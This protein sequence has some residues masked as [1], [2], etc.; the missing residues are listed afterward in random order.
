[1]AANKPLKILFLSI[2]DWANVGWS[3]ARSLRVLEDP[4]EVHTLKLNPHLFRYPEEMSLSHPSAIPE[5]AEW[6]DV[7]INIQGQ[8]NLTPFSHKTILHHNGSTAYRVN[9]EKLN[10]IHNPYSKAFFSGMMRHMHLGARNPHLIPPPVDTDLLT[11]TSQNPLSRLMVAHY[12]SSPSAK[13]SHAI[14]KLLKDLENQGRIYLQTGQTTNWSDHIHR[15]K[16][17]DVYID[18][19]PQPGSEPH[20]NKLMEWGVS[21]REAAALGKVVIS[22]CSDEALWTYRRAYF[23][24]PQILKAN[25]IEELDNLMALLLHED[26]EQ[27]GAKSRRWIVENHSYH[28]TATRLYNLI[29]LTH[30]HEAD[31]KTSPTN[32]Y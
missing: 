13:G 4:P 12:P 31:M 14:L 21:A 18:Q 22:A 1:M 3:Y 29:K 5:A 26:I 16:S 7:I 30:F 8:L 10:K 19:I 20:T 25:T 6:A 27:M 15:L 23:K 32:L 17:C 2:D 28:P 24:G 9:T 11:P